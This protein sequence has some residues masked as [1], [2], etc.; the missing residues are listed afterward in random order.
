MKK[1]IL[2]FLLINSLASIAQ[3]NTG[4]AILFIHGLAGAHTTWDELVSDLPEDYFYVGNLAVGATGDVSFED[5]ARTALM[6]QNLFY[7]CFTMDFSDNQEL[8]FVEQG[9]ELHHT[10]RF[11]R[12]QFNIDKVILFGHSMGGIAS[13]QYINDYGTQYVAGQVMV[14]SPNLGSYLGE[15]DSVNHFTDD[16][17]NKSLETERFFDLKIKTAQLKALI[18]KVLSGVDI[19]AKAVKMLAPGSREL[20]N[21][22]GVEYPPELPLVIVLSNFEPK[23]VF[24]SPKKEYLNRLTGFSKFFSEQINLYTFVESKNIAPREKTIEIFSYALQQNFTDGVVSIPSQDIRLA[25]P[26]G[27]E[28]DPEYLETDRFHL[29]TNKDIPVMHEALDIITRKKPLIPRGDSQTRN[30]GFIIDSSGSMKDN[31]PSGI[32]KTA[33]KQISRLINPLDNVFLIDFDGAANWLNS[34]NWRNWST[35][36]LAREIDQIDSNGNTDIGRALNAMKNVFSN[37]AGDFNNSGILLFTDGKSDYNNEASWF[38]ENNIPIHVVSY[39]DKA[40][41][42][43]LQ[44]IAST[45]NGEYNQAN[46]E[47][48]VVAGFMKFYQRLSNNNLFYAVSDTLMNGNPNGHDFFVDP[49][50]KNLNLILNW[51]GEAPILE[52]INPVGQ[53]ISFDKLKN[54]ILKTENYLIA[55][56]EK[57]EKGKWKAEINPTDPQNDSRYLFQANAQSPYELKLQVKKSPN[58]PIILELLSNNDEIDLQKTKVKAWATTPKGE[59]LSISRNFKNRKLRFLPRNQKGNY[60]FTVN[61]EALTQ[62]GDTISRTFRHSQFIGEI[63]PGFISSVANKISGSVIRSEVVL[64]G[65]NLSGIP[66]YIYNPGET[67]NRAKASGFVSTQIKNNLIIQLTNFAGNEPIVP[68]DIIE[69]DLISW[70]K[71]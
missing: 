16:M 46:N 1:C 67:K 54:N 48:E 63:V 62:K 61:M 12:E 11:I 9:R 69:L 66:C 64:S 60:T 57:P 19:N 15:F 24:D 70:R 41:F 22:N 40:D 59:S 35:E 21:L 39:K 32:R 25:V 33:L 20:K 7:P 18:A 14:T 52:L 10:I 26:N 49:A 65:N 13:R 51:I 58:G 8:S 5:A 47:M 71:D 34:E 27:H 23:S 53:R 42:G 45:T 28:I 31:D 44:S 29:S 37:H 36:Q 68:G 56:I 50:S 3:K 30:I 6:P 4:P 2:F 17:I 38:A 55:N 43:L